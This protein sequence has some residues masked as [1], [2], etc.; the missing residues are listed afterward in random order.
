[1]STW[2]ISKMSQNV[3]SNCLKRDQTKYCIKG[4]PDHSISNKVHETVRKICCPS[5]VY[6][7]IQNSI[8]HQ[9]I[10]T[11]KS[12]WSQTRLRVCVL[13][14]EP[15]SCE[16][17][18]VTNRYINFILDLDEEFYFQRPI[19]LDANRKHYY[20]SKIVDSMFAPGAVS[21]S[22]LKVSTFFGHKRDPGIGQKWKLT[23][24]P[25]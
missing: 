9:R 16:I 20:Q 15:V 12:F 17:T 8:T 5:S 7:P 21:H 2:F 22:K 23:L 14:Q 25:P 19:C 13:M 24:P 18:N 6:W 11:L 4:N 3:T 10:F 1:M